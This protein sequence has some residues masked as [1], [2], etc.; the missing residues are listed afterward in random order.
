MI[1]QVFGKTEKTLNGMN[2][3]EGNFRRSRQAGTRL[4]YT[5]TSEASL[6]LQPLLRFRNVAAISGKVNLTKARDSARCQKLDRHDGLEP[7][8]GSGPE[9]QTNSWRP[10]GQ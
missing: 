6:I 1:P 2:G 10:G 5:P 3:L 4:R 7:Q 9:I 8:S